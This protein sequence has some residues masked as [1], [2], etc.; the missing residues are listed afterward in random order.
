[1]TVLAKSGTDADALS[2]TL[3]VSGLERGM[4]LIEGVQGAEALFVHKDGTVR[5]TRGFP[6]G[7]EPA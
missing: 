7:R 3:M 6:F 4:D 2:T 5:A 1:V